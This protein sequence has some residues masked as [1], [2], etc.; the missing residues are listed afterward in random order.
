M[1]FI[2]TLTLENNLE[3][4]AHK[5]CRLLKSLQ[6]KTVNREKLRKALC[7]KIGKSKNVDEIDYRLLAVAY[8][9]F[10]NLINFTFTGALKIREDLSTQ[11]M[12]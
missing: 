3:I 12:G 6:C 10:T 1:W 11:S 4:S 7:H 8:P 2:Y 5:Q 9:E